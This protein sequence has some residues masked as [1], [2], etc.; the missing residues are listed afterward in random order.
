M[1][2]EVEA[3]LDLEPLHDD[4]RLGR[5]KAVMVVAKRRVVRARVF[6]VE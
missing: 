2:L 5:G 1:V 4:C 3:E 6:I